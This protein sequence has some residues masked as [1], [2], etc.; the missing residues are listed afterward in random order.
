[1]IK[2]KDISYTILHI[3]VI[4]MVGTYSFIIKDKTYDNLYI[5]LI[6]IKLFHWT[7]L[8][9]EC[10]ISYLYKK[11]K[12]KNYIPGYKL[13]NNEFN[14]CKNNKYIIQIFIILIITIL[15]LINIY[16]IFNRNNYSCKLMISFIIIYTSYIFSIYI[17]TDHYKN[18][19]FLKFQSVIQ[20][21]IILWT[22]YFYNKITF[23]YT[24]Y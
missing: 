4:I 3:I 20:L 15:T 23:K 16:N 8:N 19:N 10:I 11:S 5:L 2:L 13:I 14:D 21:S 17:F 6:C 12:N 24:Y 7:I 1:M 18:T 22:L 9:G